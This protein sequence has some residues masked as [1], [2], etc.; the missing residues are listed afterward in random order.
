MNASNT[1]LRAL[2][3]QARQRVDAKGLLNEFEEP[4]GEDLLADLGPFK[5]FAS[6]EEAMRH[7]DRDRGAGDANQ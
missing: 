1:N 2:C 5:E 7:L 4:A 6:V 3:E